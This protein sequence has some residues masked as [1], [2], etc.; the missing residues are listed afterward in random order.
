[1]WAVLDPGRELDTKHEPRTEPQHGGILIFLPTK[2]LRRHSGLG[3]SLHIPV[4]GK[5]QK[6]DEG[7]LSQELKS[8]TEATPI[9]P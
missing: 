5:L 9:D 2:K 4:C 1:M 3:G 7:G 8:R 6:L